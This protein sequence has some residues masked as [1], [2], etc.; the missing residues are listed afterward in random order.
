MNEVSARTWLRGSLHAR[1]AQLLVRLASGYD[2]RVRLAACGREADTR[3]VLDLLSLGVDVGDRVEVVAEGREAEAALSAVRELLERGFDEA[4]VPHAAHVAVPG[5]AIGRSVILAARAP[6]SAPAF[7]I[8][9]ERRRAAA[10]VAR[11]RADLGELMENLGPG[12]RE[13][14]AP[15]ADLLN[16][17]EP[18]LLAAVERGLTAEDAVVDATF[19]I[20]HDLMLD[21][22]DRVLDALDEEGSLDVSASLA[23]GPSVV[24]VRS[25]TPTLV[26]RLSPDVQGLVV[27]TLDTTAGIRAARGSH[28]VLLARG[29]GLPLAFVTVEVAESIAR[30][31]WVIVDASG[32]PA[33]VWV[34]PDAARM[35]EVSAHKA[36]DESEHAVAAARA[37]APL[38]HL[39]LAVRVNVSSL[40]EHIPEGA[41][42]VG[43]LRTELVFTGR[44]RPP[45]L[46]EQVNAYARVVAAARGGPVTIRLFD[47]GADKP[48]AWLAEPGGGSKLRGIELLFAHPEVLATQLRAV[49]AIASRGD[50]RILV[51]MT[52]DPDDVARVRAMVTG[53]TPVGAMIESMDAVRA[54]ARIA[55]AAEFLSIG[56]NDLSA[57]LVRATRTSG[58]VAGS[59]VVF[60]EVRS[61]VAA[62]HEARLLVTVCGELAGEPAAALALAGLG[63]DAISV[64]PARFLD[65]KLALLDATPEECAHAASSKVA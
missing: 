26:A 53:G 22:R 1:P 21:A 38:R 52:R 63:V 41:E 61:V 18:R 42:G 54:V 32:V 45:S 16:D 62:A 37:T 5:I 40:S 8:D 9:R 10:A 23:G 29:R 11:A 31:K 15:E 7:A 25:L 49:A 12:E 44:M 3:H 27:V 17:I 39:S 20:T 50:V 36:R 33:R 19:A 6:R 60:R 57:S 4:L 46:T 48:L 43:L 65:V 47:G 56:T 59:G 34:D 55:A 30:G 35:R 64:A 58:V 2:A 24:V 28:A 51:P 14:F 13:L